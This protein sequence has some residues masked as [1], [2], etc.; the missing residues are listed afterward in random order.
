MGL[1]VNGVIE[2]VLVVGLGSIGRRHT[3]IV[4]EL[5]SDIKII[6]LRH[7]QCDDNDVETLGLHRC[8]S[9]IE[10]A[11][12]FQPEVAIVANPA[13]KHLEVATQLAEAGV[14][15]LIEKPISASSEGVLFIILCH[16]PAL[17]RHRWQLCASFS[18]ISQLS[19]G[20]V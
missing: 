1:R 9:T 12:A 18:G 17:S 6:A 20:S 3:R 11:L 7:K 14:H 13:T 15:L 19:S 16:R 4:R 10:D 2:R 8:V 5:C